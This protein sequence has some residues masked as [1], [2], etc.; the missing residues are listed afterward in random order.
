MN[1]LNGDSLKQS[2]HCS[3]PLSAVPDLLPQQIKPVV[4]SSTNTTKYIKI[5]TSDL[6][7]GVIPS[8]LTEADSEAK[9]QASSNSQFGTY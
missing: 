7:R 8:T 1:E 9:Q 3:L 6:F 5:S 4:S 2:N